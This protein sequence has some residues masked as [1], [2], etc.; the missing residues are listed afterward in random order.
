MDDR[1]RLNPGIDAATLAAVFART[2]RIAIRDF[3]EPALAKS[4]RRHLLARQDWRLVLNAGEAVYE[5]PRTAVEALSEEQRA[6]LDRRVVAAARDGFHYRYETIRVPDDPAERAAGAELL[7][8]FVRFM[9][10]PGTLALLGRITGLSGLDFADGQATAY[11]PGHF[12]TGHD[13]DVAGKQRRAAYVLSLAPFW[14]AEWGG[15][16]MFHRADGHVDEAYVPDMG[17]LRLFAV[18]AR[19]SVSFVTPFAPEPRLSVTGWLR[20]SQSTE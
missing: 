20:S 18:P 13:D 8:G 10:A 14:R 3:V 11:S 7:D 19:H 2:G 9:S 4:L 17:S 15:L 16:L 12:L 5:M 1:F 6:E